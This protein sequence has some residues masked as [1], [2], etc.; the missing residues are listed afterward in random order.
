MVISLLVE[1]TT[2]RSDVTSSPRVVLVAGKNLLVEA[3]KCVLFKRK[4]K[5]K[6]INNLPIRAILPP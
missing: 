3:G 1:D 6:V 4:I 2:I 5:I